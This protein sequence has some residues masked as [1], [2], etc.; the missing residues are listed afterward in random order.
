MTSFPTFATT[1][2]SCS[3]FVA[4]AEVSAFLLQPPNPSRATLDTQFVQCS[5]RFVSGCSGVLGA[6]PR[7]HACGPLQA[8]LQ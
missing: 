8:P 4:R 2:D 5:I 6:L 7:D 1:C 3:V